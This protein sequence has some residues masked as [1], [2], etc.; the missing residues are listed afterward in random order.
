MVGQVLGRQAEDQAER[1]GQSYD[2]AFEDVLNTEAGRRLVE[3][4]EGLHHH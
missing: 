3:L 2:E 4:T 1:S